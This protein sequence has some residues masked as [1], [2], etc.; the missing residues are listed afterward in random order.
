MSE[1]IE[2]V[3]QLSERVVKLALRYAFSSGTS[4]RCVNILQS[5]LL[6]PA[7]YGF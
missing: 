4:C 7:S 2:S 3:I 6:V 5:V 1:A